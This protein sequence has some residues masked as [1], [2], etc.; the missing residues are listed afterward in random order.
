MKLNF[1]LIALP[2]LFAITS[3]DSK[4]EILKLDV[5]SQYSDF[6]V[7]YFMISNP[8]ENLTELLLLVNRNLDT[9]LRKQS[10]SI[11]KSEVYNQVYY[12]EDFFFDRNY[13]PH[14]KWYN[15]FISDD[16][17]NGESHAEDKI[18][19]VRIKSNRDSCFM[20]PRLP[21]YMIYKKKLIYYP[22]GFRNNP[23]KH[24]EKM[25]D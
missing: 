22:N 7:D 1:F 4:T 8:P 6:H 5:Q 3:C 17:R 24:W 10:S 21:F 19:S 12:K 20:C 13:K 15:N 23:N 16:I 18:I 2:I 9:T 14:F 11:L 25:K